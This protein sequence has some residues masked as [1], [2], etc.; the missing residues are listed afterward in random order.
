MN[1]HL[2]QLI[3]VANLDKGID[4]LEPKIAQIKTKLNRILKEKEKKEQEIFQI[5]EENAELLLRNK[6]TQTMIEEIAIR[7]EQIAKKHNEV[8]SEREL[9]AL[10]IEEE[11]AKEQLTKANQDIEDIEKIQETKKQKL[12]ELQEGIKE[13]QS[14]IEAEEKEVAKEVGLV[15]AEQEKLYVKRQELYALLDQKLAIFYEKIRNWAKNTS[16][17]PVKK[18]ACGGCFIRINDRIYAEVKQSND[19]V[20]C[21]HCGRILYIENA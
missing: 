20:N 10:V 11:L 6:N 18:Q 9:K 8:K 5:E 2:Q 1:K 4:L 7:L 14:E 15:E 3:E 12:I 17:V 13:L 16:I 21:P 19:I